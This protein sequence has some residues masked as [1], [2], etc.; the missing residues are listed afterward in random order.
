MLV[1]FAHLAHYD[2]ATLVSI[3]ALSLFIPAAGLL[4]VARSILQGLE[5]MEYI[6]LST[7]LGSIVG[8]STLWLLLEAKVGVAAAF[9]ANGFSYL[10]AFAVLAFFIDRHVRLTKSSFRLDLNLCQRIIRVSLPFALQEFFK[11]A[12]V[13]VNTIVLPMLV[14]LGTVGVFDAADRVQQASAMIIPMVILSITPTLSRIFITR[15]EIA[16]TLLEDALKLLLIL[17][18]PFAFGVTIA[19][20]RIIPLIYGAGYEAAVPVLRIVIWSMVFFIANVIFTQLLIASDNERPMMRRTGLTLAI[21]IFLTLWLAPRY[22]ALGIAW[23]AIWTQAINFGL[24]AQFVLRNVCRINLIK[25]AGKPFL[26]AALSGMVAFSLQEQGLIMSLS[27]G[28]LSY[29]ASLWVFQ[30]FSLEEW[31]GLWHLFRQLLKS[32]RLAQAPREPTKV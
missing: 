18:L 26:C 28:T 6:S 23:I 8:V 19:A 27:F 11:V 9:I 17:V 30:V 12:L 31:F 1:S 15:R 2:A 22:G 14:T 29:I 24:N 13:R 21:N 5:R 16:I 4:I 7:F 32:N 10:V 20:D 3:N 25:A